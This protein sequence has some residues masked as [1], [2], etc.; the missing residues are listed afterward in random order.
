MNFPPNYGFP[1][2]PFAGYQVPP[3]S[4]QEGSRG[5]MVILGLELPKAGV[6]GFSEFRVSY[7]VGSQRYEWTVPYAVVGC[8]P[9][10][11]YKQVAHRSECAVG[12]LL[13][14]G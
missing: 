3:V 1:L 10:S 9:N 6:C 14:P 7:H 13:A 11:F 4:T 12:G 8:A 5:V 2:S